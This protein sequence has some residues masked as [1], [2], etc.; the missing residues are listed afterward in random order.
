MKGFILILSLLF[1]LY[2]GVLFS[3]ILLEKTPLPI[4]RYTPRENHTP[5]FNE[6]KCIFWTPF[7]LENELTCVRLTERNY[8]VKIYSHL[9]KFLKD[10]LQLLGHGITDLRGA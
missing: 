4:N 5:V 2:I 3:V 8:R 9:F 6:N 7:F 10:L 1:L